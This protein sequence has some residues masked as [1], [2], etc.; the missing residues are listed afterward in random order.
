MADHPRPGTVRDQPAGCLRGWRR[1][2]RLRQASRRGGWRGIGCRGL[3]ARLPGR[4]GRLLHASPTLSRS[5]PAQTCDD[6]GDLQRSK[7]AHNPRTCQLLGQLPR[8]H[9]RVRISTG[10]PQHREPLQSE[11]RRQLDNVLRPIRQPA[12]RLKVRQPHAAGCSGRSCSPPR[13]RRHSGAAG[14]ASSL[15][16]HP[17]LGLHLGHRITGQHRQDG[18]I[19]LFH[20]RHS[21]LCQSQLP[22]R[23]RSACDAMRSPNAGSAR[24]VESAPTAC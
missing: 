12:T 19:P 4:T 2:P 11:G 22:D 7:T 14:Y 9:R 3:R 16:R 24:C 8:A 20:D 13:P 10:D 17:D 21:H 18:L 15:P 6:A 1:S 23:G 5:P